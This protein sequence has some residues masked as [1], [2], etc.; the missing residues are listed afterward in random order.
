MNTQQ[1][2]AIK[3]IDMSRNT[4]LGLF[5]VLIVI[6]NI[7]SARGNYLLYGLL[8]TS[9]GKWCEL[10]VILV[11]IFYCVIRFKNRLSSKIFNKYFAPIFLGLFI[12]FYNSVNVMLINGA[13]NWILFEFLIVDSLF[14]LILLLLLNKLSSCHI[15]KEAMIGQLSR[16]YIYISM[17]S[18][19]GVL[20]SFGLLIAGYNLD[21][22]IYADY[23]ASNVDESNAQYYRSFLTV[24]METV[25]LRVPFF[26]EYGFLCGLFH[27]PH[28]FA[29]NVF[30]CLLLM[31]AFC[32]TKLVRLLVFISLILVILFAGSATNVFV[33]LGCLI[34]YV[35]V[36]ARR[37]FW[38]I[39]LL[40]LILTVAVYFYYK[41]DTTLF[42]FLIERS[43]SDHSSRQYSTSL[44][45]FAF[46]PRTLTGTDCFS[47]TFI[48][49]GTMRE[50]VGWIVFLL[51][52]SFLISYLRNVLLLLFKKE[53]L[54]F[55]IGISS[56]YFIAHS[57]KVGLCMFTSPLFIVFVFLQAVYLTKFKTD[58]GKK[59]LCVQNNL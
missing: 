54:P 32:K 43:S 28:I 45:E 38:G 59:Q 40:L 34:V 53:K 27:E 13:G 15:P 51:Y 49:H 52:V 37:N 29:Y 46:T 31:L 4:K 56:L 36:R 3:S 1:E 8:G 21:T 16:G 55:I 11:D 33:A 39:L 5:D 35:L 17:F 47:T 2:K 44:L 12:I 26:Q 25:D 23:M 48:S 19:I 20:L 24:R 9:E 42:D 50:D 7:A 14:F 30:P 10:F 6:M 18:F 22:P 57:A 58:K 41:I